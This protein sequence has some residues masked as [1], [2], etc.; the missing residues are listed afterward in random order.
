MLFDG[1][2]KWI[3]VAQPFPFYWF[4]K[5]FYI[6]TYNLY[7]LQ[8][9]PIIWVT[10]KEK[11]KK[12]PI[13]VGFVGLHFSHATNITPCHDGCFKRDSGGHCRF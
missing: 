6:L 5:T 13:F 7:L 11:T 8:M 2:L 3:A 1:M 4:L 9:E 12:C 10:F